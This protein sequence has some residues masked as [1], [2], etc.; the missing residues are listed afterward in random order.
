MSDWKVQA[1]QHFANRR[2]P[3][4]LREIPVPEW[5]ISVFYWP[6]ISLAEDRAIKVGFQPGSKIDGDGV[7][8]I[9]VDAIGG[10]VTELVVRGRDQH[11][12]RLFADDEFDDVLKGYDP[13]VVERVISK[14]ETEYSDAESAEKK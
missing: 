8:A 13:A 12:R 3:E 5:G 2:S 10:R 1:K 7:R 14:M 4:L 11:G 9:R 6:A